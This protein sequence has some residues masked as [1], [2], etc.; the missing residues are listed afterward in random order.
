MDADDDRHSGF[1]AGYASNDDDHYGGGGGGRPRR[2][3]GRGRAAGMIALIVVVVV[4]GG[5]GLTGYHFYSEYKSRHASYT[6]NGFGTVDVTCRRVPPRCRCRRC[7][8][9]RA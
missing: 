2:G 6:G 4:L 7:W 9:A 8:L 3:R 5:L 1:F